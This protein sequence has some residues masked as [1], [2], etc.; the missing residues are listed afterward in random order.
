[1][2]IEEVAKQARGNPALFLAFALGR[3][4][5][6]LQR[7]M[8]NHALN[9]MSWY[10]EIP[11]GHAKTSTFTYLC[12]WW[13][14]VRPDTRI[15]IISQTDEH[16]AKTSKFLLDVVRSDAFKAT[17]PE[18]TVGGECAITSWSVTARGIA[19]R[20]D[21][22]VVSSGV[23][24][25]TGGRADLIWFDDICDLRNAVLQ[26]ALRSQVKEAVGNI[27]IPMLDPSSVYQSRVWRT[28]TPFHTDDITADWRR[29]HS[30]DGTM[31]RRPCTA[32][33][34]PWSEI[35]TPE[36]LKE[37]RDTIGIMAYARAYELVPLSSDLLVFRPEWIKYYPQ[38][39]I[40]PNTRTVAAIDWGYGRKEQDREDPDYSVCLIGQVDAQRRLYLTDILRVR[41]S[42]PTFAKMVS[43]LL[44]RRR[45][46]IV[47]AEANG[48][49]KGIF[50]QFSTLTSLPLVAKQRTTD[51]HMR[52]AASQPFVTN[53]KLLFPTD[54][55]GKISAGLQVVYD[56]MMTFPAG[57]HDD[58]VD[59]VVDLCEE[60]VRGLL[61]NKEVNGSKF[62]KQ[63]AIQRLFGAG[64]PKRGIFG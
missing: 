25:R 52:A 13:L 27:W 47:V 63:D 42:F 28:S 19:A 37:R 12:A 64:S 48:P 53:G 14:G 46:S 6:H 34:S 44:N 43:E 11:R 56:E 38:G 50:D 21:P 3:P 15:K 62:E 24:G 57:T 35:F 4:V 31:L 2:D 22:S 55:E 39:D 17:F 16:A 59:C 33:E 8:I 30:E 29:H 49:Q 5:A 10:M 45:V 41:E 60:A 20:R 40:P 26:P 7:E 18:V 54:S 58:T 23:F 32:T 51:K 36:I 61:S 9:H 1:M